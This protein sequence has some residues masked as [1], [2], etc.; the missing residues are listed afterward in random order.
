[1]PVFTP[2]NNYSGGT[3]QNSFFKSPS[4]PQKKSTYQ[5][6]KTTNNGGSPIPIMNRHNN[7][8]MNG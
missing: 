1:M 8:A 2:N 5:P 6:A 7:N 4:N 3:N